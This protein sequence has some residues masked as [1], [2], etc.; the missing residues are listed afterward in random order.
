MLSAS[1]ASHYSD[2]V[3]PGFG[4]TSALLGLLGLGHSLIALKPLIA[5]T[6]ARGTAQFRGRG[7][8]D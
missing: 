3:L 5:C 1:L 8:E 7:Q 6:V 4:S 2:F